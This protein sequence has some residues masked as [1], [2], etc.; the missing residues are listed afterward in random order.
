MSAIDERELALGKRGA[1][2]DAY[3]KFRRTVHSLGQE[4]YQVWTKTVFY[5][6]CMNL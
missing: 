6:R 3:W 2:R 4:E 5:F 1:Q